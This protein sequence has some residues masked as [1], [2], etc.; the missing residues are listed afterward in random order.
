MSDSTPSPESDASGKTKKSFFVFPLSTRILHWLAVGSVF[1][2]LWSGLWILN[3][4]PRLYW[5]DVGYF[6]APAI[7][8][9][10]GDLS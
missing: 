3:I 6:G 2:L 10:T 4:H 1:T 7:A 9:I 8:E 5:G